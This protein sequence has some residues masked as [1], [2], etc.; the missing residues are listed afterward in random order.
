LFVTVQIKFVKLTEPTLT[1]VEMTPVHAY[2]DGSHSSVAK[3]FYGIDYYTH[4]T[5]RISSAFCGDMTDQSRWI[6]FGHTFLGLSFDMLACTAT[7]LIL[8]APALSTILKTSRAICGKLASL[9]FVCEAQ[10]TI[11]GAMSIRL[12]GTLARSMF[13]D[14]FLQGTFMASKVKRTRSTISRLARGP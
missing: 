9:F 2:S 12:H 6:L 1:V 10:M 14:Q 3:D 7:A 11:H 5:E 8:S 13:H 4:V